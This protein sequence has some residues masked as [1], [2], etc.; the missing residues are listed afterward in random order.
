[1]ELFGWAHLVTLAATV[2]GASALAVAGRRA[3]AA[4]ARWIAL[5][6]AGTLLLNELVW[7]GYQV[8]N[9]SWNVRSSLPLHLCDAAIIVCLVALLTRNRVA[10]ELA[11]FWGF[12]GSVQALLTP[13]VGAS[14]P[15]YE[16]F[17]YFLSHSGIVLIVSYLT[18][19]RR[20]RPRSGCVLRST[21]ITGV[22]TAAVGAVNLL[23]SANYMFL[24]GKPP[25][26]S[27]MDVLGPWPWYLAS[28]TAVGALTIA[29]LYLPWHLVD[30]RRA[31][32]PSSAFAGQGE[33]GRSI[34][35]A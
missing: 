32:K 15:D 25:E 24:C 6:L 34:P 35:L 13:S 26:A 12:G 18:F 9:G 3:S 8:W 11:Y 17:R 29:L 21:V 20:M 2:A 33:S 7:H 28:L 19:G 16:F 10:C 1:M 4:G 5:V 23:L 14:F 31:V 30:R 27:L 22:Y